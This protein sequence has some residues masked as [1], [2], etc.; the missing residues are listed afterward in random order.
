MIFYTFGIQRTCTNF[1]KELILKNF[2]SKWGNINDFGHWSW[3]HSPD[4]EQATANLSHSTPLV[5]CYKTPLMWV[6]SII[7]NDVDFINR[8]GLAKYPDY[9]DEELLW[10]NALYKFSIPMAIEKWIEF[11]REWMKFI[12]R[13][14]YII[15]NQRKMCAQPGAIEVLSN[16][17]SKLQLQKKSPQWTLFNNAV[18]Y[19]VG[20]T[21]K[22]FDER[23]K[24]Y[25]EN[26]TTK[27]TPKQIQYISNKIP[28]EIISF[29][30]KEI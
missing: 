24:K 23:K 9:H 2:H 10:E 22:D 19:R 14:N 21:D 28:Q 26:K 6:E 15:M 5:F 12:H 4:A 7:R 18:D 20:L 8:W 1:A 27:L 13:S 11:H 30:E 25:L 29:F 16:I 17:E 3:K